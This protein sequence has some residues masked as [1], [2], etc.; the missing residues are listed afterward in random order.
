MNQNFS[1]NMYKRSKESKSPL[2]SVVTKVRG[3]KYLIQQTVTL[4][5]GCNTSGKGQNHYKKGR[6]QRLKRK[7]Y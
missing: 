6:L 5:P 2:F 1:G 4:K 7:K 3:C